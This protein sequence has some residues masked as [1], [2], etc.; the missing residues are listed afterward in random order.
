M[1]WTANVT[2]KTLK[3]PHLPLLSAAWPAKHAYI[4][5]VAGVIS[6]FN[7]PHAGVIRFVIIRPGPNP[8]SLCGIILSEKL[9]L[10]RLMRL[11]VSVGSFAI[12]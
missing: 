4:L 1:M 11:S 12:R 10:S 7:S 5:F 6:S 8:L 3:S 9:K 2:T